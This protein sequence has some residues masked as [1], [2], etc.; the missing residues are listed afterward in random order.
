LLNLYRND[1]RQH[2]S[3]RYSHDLQARTIDEKKFIFES[4]IQ[5]NDMVNPRNNKNY[6]QIYSSALYEMK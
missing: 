3:N 6:H 4:N 1:D 2:L 5:P